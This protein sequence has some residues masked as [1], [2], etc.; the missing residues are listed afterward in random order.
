[1]VNGPL[2]RYAKLQ[3][4][5][6]PGMP[7]TFSPAAEFEG[8]RY[9]AIPACIT[10]RSWRTCRD[11]CRDRLPAVTGKTFPA[12]PAHAHLYFCVSGKRPMRWYSRHQ[13]SSGRDMFNHLT[14]T[15]D[16]LDTSINQYL[17]TMVLKH[18]W[19]RSQPRENALWTVIY[20][21]LFILTYVSFIPAT[22]AIFN[23]GPTKTYTTNIKPTTRLYHSKSQNECHI[24]SWLT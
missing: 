11:A 4:A 9:L 17:T 7:G 5:H 10:A 8:N 18:Q 16:E 1:M 3:V 22:Y 21:L 13:I 12:F 19:P 20:Y 14:Y 15:F 24:F 2:T 6:A 23:V